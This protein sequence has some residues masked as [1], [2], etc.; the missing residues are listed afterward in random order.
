[1]TSMVDM[2]RPSRQAVDFLSKRQPALGCTVPPSSI[3]LSTNTRFTM[4]KIS[5]L[6][7]NKAKPL[8][9]KATDLPRLTQRRGHQ[10]QDRRTMIPISLTAMAEMHNVGW[11]GF[12]TSMADRICSFM[13]L[14]FGLS[15]MTMAQVVRIT[16]CARLML[17]GPTM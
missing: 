6:A 12:R 14:A 3:T 10:S 1:M 17:S 16:G 4:P 11:H 5:L 15:S 7:C 8:T 9:G 13:A 2:A